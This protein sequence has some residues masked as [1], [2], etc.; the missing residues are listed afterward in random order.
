[1]KHQLIRLLPLLALAV[2][3]LTVI[4]Q[5]YPKSPITIVVPLAPGDAGDTA[6]RSMSEELSRQLQVP[7][8]VANRPGAGGAI[9]TQSVVSAAKDGYTLL[10]TQNGPLTI[11]RVFDPQTASYDPARDLTALA[12]SSRTPSILVVRKEAPFNNFRELVEHAKKV[13]GSVRIG[14]A[15]AGSAGDISVQIIN[16][17]AGI[18][19][20]SV[21]Y[22][23]AAPAVT[24]ALGG[25]VEGVVLGLGAVSA[26]LKSGAFKG[27]AISSRVAELPQVPTLPE[28]GYKQGILGVWFA[29]FAPAGVP[30]EV[31]Q[32]LVPAL[33]RTARNPAITARLQPMGIVQDWLAP[34]ALAAE[35]QREFD[36]VSEIAKNNPVRKP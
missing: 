35:V 14:N 6:L 11:R 4:A 27:I 19:I 18:D 10:F 15:G 32:A 5:G 17:L 1:M 21:P 9:A 13:P 30:A 3:P 33:E 24:D 16:T 2:T 22:K 12:L 20:V 26:H 36:S 31:V 25:Q 34:P 23:G 7:I 28:L 29:F 8:T